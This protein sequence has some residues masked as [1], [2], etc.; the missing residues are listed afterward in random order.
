MTRSFSLTPGVVKGS[1]LGHMASTCAPTF[2]RTGLGAGLCAFGC[3]LLLLSSPGLA[4]E[5][6][7]ESGPSRPG[8]GFNSGPRPVDPVLDRILQQQEL[9]ATRPGA[10]FVPSIAVPRSAP[11]LDPEMQRRWSIELDKRRNWLLEN[12]SQVNLRR[13]GTETGKEDSPRFSQPFKGLG[14]LESAQDRYFRSTESNAANSTGDNRKP[15]DFDRQDSNGGF[16]PE[17]NPDAS[18]LSATSRSNTAGGATNQP[19]VFQ[20]YGQMADPAA[21]RREAFTE[22]NG[23]FSN[24]AASL[25]DESRLTALE[26]RTANFNR[27]LDPDLPKGVAGAPEAAAGGL[28]LSPFK[29]LIDRPSRSQQFQSLLTGLE[30]SAATSPAFGGP[31]QSATAARP[32]LPAG[33]DR[34]ASFAAPVAAIIA[35]PPVSTRLAPRPAV[36]TIP[37][38]GF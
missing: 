32:A 34:S 27:L 10:D 26:Q 38:R 18:P 15:G 23:L 14:S 25:I 37:T 6:L 31:A 12:A 9:N 11:S 20:R 33:F 16:S 22:D 4:G 8:T 30:P 5:K 1:K 7:I 19:G 24:P 28:G 13:S 17:F 36:L 35:P 21:L 2:S 3:G 29:S